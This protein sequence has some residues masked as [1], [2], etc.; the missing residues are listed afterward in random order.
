M[1]DNPFV[2]TS[3]WAAREFLDERR[4]RTVSQLAG[5]NIGRTIGVR[6]Q[7]GTDIFHVGLAVGA[8]AVGAAIYKA[9]RK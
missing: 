5:W 6:A 1:S 7:T 2:A 3:Q 4:G 8:V 9:I